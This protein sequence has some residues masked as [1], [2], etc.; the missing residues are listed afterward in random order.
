[1]APVIPA[2]VGNEHDH[3]HEAEALALAHHLRDLVD[4]ETNGVSQGDIAILLRA[5]TRSQLYVNALRQVGLVPYLASGG[6]FWKTREVVELKSILSVIAN[7]LD[8][9]HL[10]G[11]LTSPACGLSTDALWLLRKGS[12]RHQPLWP[13]LEALAGGEA[14]TP[15]AQGWLEKVPDLDRERAVRFVDTIASLRR[16]SAT[17][18]LAE[19]IEA[20]VAETGYD[21]ANLVR[22]PSANGFAAI[23]R[24]ESLAREYEAAEGRS[25]RGF[26]DWARLSEE[27]DSEA[28][29]ATA[30]ESSD[31]V[32]VMTVHAAKGL[33]F[34]VTCV[35]DLGRQCSSRHEHAL[36][37]GRSSGAD[38]GDFELGLRLP[39]FDGGRLNAYAWDDLKDYESLANE[40]EE[41]RLLHVA[42]TRAE[43]HLVL[44]GV[45]P[46]KWNAGD[47]I[48]EA[49]PMIRRSLIA[50]DLDPAED[51][52]P[53][54]FA[55]GEGDGHE[56][57]IIRNDAS[58]ERA[59]VLRRERPPTAVPAPSSSGAPPLARPGVEVYPD[60][61]LSFTA[62]AE[63]IECPARF[64]AKRVLKVEQP[65][66]WQR[67]GEAATESLSGRSRGTRFGS[68]VHDVLEQLANS[69]W[70]M[71]A[72][73]TV[74][75]ALVRN[76]LSAGDPEGDVERAKEMISGFLDSEL[77]RR[78]AVPGSVA[79]V[80]L[81]IRCEDVTIRGSADLIHGS[82]P[83]LVLDYKTNRL[84]GSSPEEKMRSYD[85]QRGLYALA[86]ARA[87]HRQSVDTAYVFLERPEEPVFRTYATADFEEVEAKLRDTLGEIKSGHFFGGPGGQSRPCGQDDCAGCRLLGAQIARATPEAA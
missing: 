73:E 85:L 41:L 2:G 34:K 65:G 80:P 31:V 25:L 84:E 72:S 26:L 54:A 5:K 58:Q 45:L 16:R 60:V 79:E 42:M 67:A 51:E 39:R 50:L 68:A 43:N 49:A 32:R 4:D 18:P 69:G 36:R 24:A 76:G 78:V 55:I 1:M 20:A 53:E 83:P 70:R 82:K 19:L 12:E 81:L 15:E 11:A 14:A 10:L 37:L 27:L 74:E 46:R 87:Q 64:Y 21:L 28:S 63:F 33:Q 22:D 66:E 77:G 23:R 29:A 35:P 52:W 30:D 8:D 75:E 56:I 6:G 17:L 47:G 57:R 86:V 38:P 7:P 71:P 9:N 3:F 59:A 62:F 40:D 61:P 13:A 48:T 44:C